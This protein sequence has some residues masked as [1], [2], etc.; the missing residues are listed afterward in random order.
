MISASLRKSLPLLKG[1]ST[2]NETKRKNVLS[3]IGKDETIYNALREIAHNTIK[4]NVKLNNTQKQKLQ[5]HKKTLKSLCLKC[6]CAKRRQKLVVQSGGF[7][8]FLIPAV[9]SLVSSI[10]AKNV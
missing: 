5:R 4:G 10:I 1:I 3:Q 2:L 7:L 8:P 6:K 9:A